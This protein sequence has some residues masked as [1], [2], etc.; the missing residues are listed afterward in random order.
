MEV[1]FI[2]LAGSLVIE[3]FVGVFSVKKLHLI[4]NDQR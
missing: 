1:F 3:L 2:T 4:M